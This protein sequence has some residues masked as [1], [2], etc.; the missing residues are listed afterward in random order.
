M[1]LMKYFSISNRS[2]KHRVLIAFSIMSVIPLLALT[3]FLTIYVLA[4]VAD[5]PQALAV[6]IFCFW[7]VSMGYIILR[8]VINPITE[9]ANRA[10][11]IAEGKY[12]SQIPFSG[13][14]ELGEIADA[15]NSMT[16]RMRT[17]IG[18]LQEYGKRTSSLNAR[19]HR[20][21]LTLT[22]LMRLGEII[23]SGASF[24][25]I[26]SFA[27]ERLA[28]Q[29]NKGFCAIFVKEGVSRYSL[30]AFRDNS[31]RGMDLSKL[32]ARLT[33][34]EELLPGHE[35]LRVDSDP[36]K[37]PWQQHLR[38]ELGRVDAIFFPMKIKT[39]IVGMI[40]AGSFGEDTR[41]TSEDLEVIRAFDNELV[42]GYQST[43]SS[44]KIQS[45]QI[46]DRVTGLYTFS[47]LRERLDDEINRAI[48]YQRPCSLI[49]ADI[50]GF[51]DIALKSGADTAER[52]LRDVARLLS[53]L[54]PPVGKVARFGRSEF[55]MLLPEMNKKESLE[56][57]ELV[58]AAIEEMPVPTG[59]GERLTVS[60]GAGEN[61]I[62]GSTADEII[63][64][65]RVFTR[66]AKEMGGNMVVGE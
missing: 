28:G 18:E 35:H 4:N 26:T 32:E 45:L 40:V 61:P 23:S 10:R 1:G 21:V 54:R 3:Y 8:Q 12:D 14:D 16:S 31:H 50:D 17:Y 65:A 30:K 57:G 63:E 44:E 24:E 25:E 7:L 41:F 2:L 52:I 59:R 49:V 58:R 15:V 37:E 46:V 9:M 11:M 34:V 56:V 5:I 43:V 62:D 20:K 47:F 38:Q 22:N 39:S 51:A 66:R 60:V 42:L 6:I 48:F 53:E 27:A 13:D 19:I 64:K 29:M 55:A 33:E 36:L